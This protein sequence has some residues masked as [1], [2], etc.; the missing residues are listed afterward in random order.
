MPQPP[1]ACVLVVD[2]QPDL[3]ESTVALLELHG[4]RAVGA[5]GGREAIEAA[6]ADPP[7]VALLD[8]AMPEVDGFEVARR[9]GS[10][11]PGRR[12]LL[13]AVTGLEAD[14]DRQRAAEVGFAL[15]LI[16]PVP[17]D[18]LIDVV[19]KCEQASEWA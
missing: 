6:A 1:P 19:R 4:F 15:Y 9:L 14:T 17:P 12:P 18:E 3:V 13:V 2:D 7:S 11:S 8:L 5:T 16:K 10:Q